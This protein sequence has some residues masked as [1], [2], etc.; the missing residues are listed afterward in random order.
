M[1]DRIIKESICTSPNIDELSWFEEVVFYRLIVNCDDFGRT[2]GRLPVLKARLFP[3]KDV[4]IKQL[5][6]AINRLST[7]GMVVR[8]KTNGQPFLQLV[9]WRKHQRIRNKRSKYPFPDEIITPCDRAEDI[10][11]RADSETGLEFKLSTP[12]DKSPDDTCCQLT[13]NAVNCRS[14]PIQSNPNQSN[15]SFSPSISV[16]IREGEKYTFE[17]FWDVYPN[18]VHRDEAE[19]CFNSLIAEGADAGDIIEAAIKYKMHAYATSPNFYKRPDNFLG[20]GVWVEYCSRFKK[21]CPLC[22]GEG[23]YEENNEMHFPCSCIDRNKKFRRE[24]P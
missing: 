18:Q 6:D 22:K 16:N 12:V 2:D 21:D 10:F 13:S 1:S 24:K 11:I 20:M 7:A 17:Q 9:T 4:T 8:Y 14:N 3:L 19:R 5:D 23:C 15:H